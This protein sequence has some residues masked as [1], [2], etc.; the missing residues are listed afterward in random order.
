MTIT[1]SRARGNNSGERGSNPKA[2]FTWL[3]LLNG[4]IYFEIELNSRNRLNLRL[5]SLHW[6]V[7]RHTKAPEAGRDR[8]GGGIFFATASTTGRSTERPKLTFLGKGGRRRQ[9]RRVCL[10]LFGYVRVYMGSSWDEMSVRSFHRS[11][12]AAVTSLS[13][14]RRASIPDGD[15]FAWLPLFRL[16]RQFCTLL[17]KNNAELR[18]FTSFT[19]YWD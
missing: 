17:C 9:V 19:D 12:A 16:P 5:Q 11:R 6:T 2:K 14:L 1:I 15:H 8:G 13:I 3:A 18:W 10:C 7:G 4:E